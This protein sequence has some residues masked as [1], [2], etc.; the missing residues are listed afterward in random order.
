MSH[1]KY[2]K[3]F[4]TVMALAL[5]SVIGLWSFNVLSELF[6]GP[7]FKFKHA[8]AI[9]GLLLIIKWTHNKQR[10]NHDCGGVGCD[11]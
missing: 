2:M 9:V 10:H 11:H 8:V 5:V 4:I 1:D 7:L 3:L 6:G